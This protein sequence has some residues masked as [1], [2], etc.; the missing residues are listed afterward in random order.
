V[1]LKFRLERGAAEDASEDAAEDDAEA[2]AEADDDEEEGDDEGTLRRVHS[3]PA[4]ANPKH[5]H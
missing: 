5:W 1:P 4:E 3:P 2:D